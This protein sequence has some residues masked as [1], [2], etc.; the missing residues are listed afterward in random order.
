MNYVRSYASGGQSKGV[1][2][3]ILGARNCLKKKL[4]Y[5]ILAHVY[6]HVLDRIN[7]YFTESLA[8]SR[9]PNLNF[10]VEHQQQLSLNT[11]TI[12]SYTVSLT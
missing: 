10:T 5:G 2:V 6:E 9:L 7:C 11:P 1:D 3:G 8:K 4:H 12:Q